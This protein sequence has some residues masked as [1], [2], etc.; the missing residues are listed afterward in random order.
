MAESLCELMPYAVGFPDALG[1][2]IAVRSQHVVSVATRHRMSAFIDRYE[3]ALSRFRDDSLVRAMGSARHG[4][5]F[6]FPDWAQ[7]LFELYDRLAQASSGAVD[8][9]VGEDL[10]RLGYGADLTF[11][12]R[13]DADGHLGGIHGR[14]TWRGDIQRRGTTLITH[15]PVH[16]DFGACGK[17]YLVDL[18]TGMLDDGWRMSAPPDATTKNAVTPPMVIDAGGDLRIRAVRSIAIALEDPCDTDDAVGTA[19]IGSG[20]FCASAPSRRRWGEMHHLLNAMDG[21]PVHDVAA[22][23]VS[24]ASPAATK[25]ENRTA[26]DM[27]SPPSAELTGSS[28]DAAHPTAT[29]DGLAT[30]LFVVDPAILARSFRFECAVL[31]A[32]RHA[33]RSAHFPGAFFTR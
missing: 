5:A 6:A 4:G 2:G 11:T 17:G 9:C 32:D 14:P 31:H 8:P 1:T 19:S 15:R 10:I 7:G 25:A 29:A 33:S 22:T 21:L 26:D 27:V 23:W 12:M 3:A 16:L 24:I 18:L 20:S 13:P 28:A 30:A